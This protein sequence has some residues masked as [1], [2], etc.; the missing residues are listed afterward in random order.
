MNDLKIGDIVYVRMEIVSINRLAKGVE[1]NLIRMA[2][3]HLELAKWVK[4][5][6][7]IKLKPPTPP[8][9]LKNKE[10]GGWWPFKKKRKKP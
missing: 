10:Q 7:I 5:S 2:G 6:E 1:Y 3:D 4:P 8:E 9:P